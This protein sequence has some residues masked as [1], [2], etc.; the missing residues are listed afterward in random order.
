MKFVPFVLLTICGLI[1]ISGCGQSEES[2]EVQVEIGEWFIQP[3]A[4]PLPAGAVSLSVHNDGR[5]TH[6]LELYRR[7]GDIEEYELAEITAIKPGE[8]ATLDFDLESGEYELICSIVERIPNGPVLNHYD[9]GM[10]AII[11]VEP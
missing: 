8:T 2:L 6:E 9:L 4:N 5:F 3:A 10:G 1:S 11:V 7:F